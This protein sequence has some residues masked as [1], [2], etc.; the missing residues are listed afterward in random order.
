[1]IWFLVT[2]GW[3]FV[4]VCFAVFEWDNTGNNYTMKQRIVLFIT[5]TILGPLN[6]LENLTW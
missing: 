1:M 3:L 4:G 5:R 2:L 6:F